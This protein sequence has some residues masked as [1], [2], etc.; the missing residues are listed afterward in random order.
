MPSPIDSTAAVPGQ[1]GSGKNSDNAIFPSQEKPDPLNGKIAITN[2]EAAFDAF[3]EEQCARFGTKYP[4]QVYERNKNWPVFLQLSLI[5]AARGW[6]PV[7]YVHKTF[8]S[9]KKSSDCLLVKD[10]VSTRMLDGY[11]PETARI[12]Y[13][14]EYGQCIQ[15]LIDNEVG[16]VSEHSLLMSPLTPFPAWFR[17]FYP[18]EIDK[19]I[20][21]SWSEMAKRE[22]SQSSALIEFLKGIDPE[23]WERVRKMLWFYDEPKGGAK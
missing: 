9:T 16:G 19:E 17:V 5:C 1:G 15:L 10:L 4:T 14:D 8:G 22:I 18:E 6:D 13:K 11:R 3:F 2:A 21:D 23:K 12:A 7:D 20:F